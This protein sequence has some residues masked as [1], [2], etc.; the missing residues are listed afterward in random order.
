MEIVNLL[1]V[2]INSISNMFF[3][4]LAIIIKNH[5]GYFLTV[6]VGR[7][8]YI[9]RQRYIRLRD[10]AQEYALLLK[11]RFINGIIPSCEILLSLKAIVS[12]KYDITANEMPFKEKA[13]SSAYSLCLMD[14][15]IP[16]VQKDWF[17]NN[18]E[19]TK[20]IFCKIDKQSPKERT[21]THIKK[22]SLVYFLFYSALY[23]MATFFEGTLFA[24]SMRDIATSLV[25]FAVL[26]WVMA[27]FITLFKKF[28]RDWLEIELTWL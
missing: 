13:F 26:S 9:K 8:I 23:I 20:E 27:L 14:S 12:S 11:D 15:G 28:A 19:K 4:S 5:G 18:L 10:A 21:P 1:A 25:I 24:L 6:L 2:I 7:I 22:D 17:Y 16:E 3:N